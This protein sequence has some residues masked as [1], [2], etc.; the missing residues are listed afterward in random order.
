MNIRLLFLIPLFFIPYSEALAQYTDIINASRPGVSQ[1]AFSVGRDVFQVETGVSMGK[2]K[3]ELENT[4]TDALGVDYSIRYGMFSE[5]LE[6]SIMGEFM[7]HSID[8]TAY[9]PPKNNKFA[10]FKSNTLGAKYLIYDPNKKGP[11]TPPNLYSWH[12]NHK[13]TW[14]DL[15]PAISIYAGF[16]IDV[17][18]DNHFVQSGI[19]AV[20]PKVVIATQNNWRGGWVFVSNIILDRVTTSA[21]SFGY[22]LTLTHATHSHFSLFIENQGINSDFYSDQL[23]RGGA[24]ALITPNFQVDLSAT[25]SFKDTPSLLYGRLGIAYRLDFHYKNEYVEF[26]PPDRLKKKEKKQKKN[27]REKN[28][29]VVERK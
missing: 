9:Q 3:H 21:A 24:A 15:I 18:N 20:S 14:F 12:A 17:V 8:Y 16:N 29:E 22:I 1:G 2:E 25:Y 4:E 11:E 6:F 13:F 19:G 26:I 23:L 10:N 28:L 7:A 5:R 27:K